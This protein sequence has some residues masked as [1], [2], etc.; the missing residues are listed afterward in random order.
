[1]LSM[2]SSCCSSISSRIS[3]TYVPDTEGSS[4]PVDPLA[5]LEKST[6]AKEHLEKVQIPRLEGL[7]DVSEHYNSD[8]YS[9]STKVRK[10]FRE[11]KKV[12]KQKAKADDQLRG[13]YGLPESLKL[14]EDDEKAR[15]EAKAEW[16]RGQRE[17]HLRESSKRRKL[18][19]E[20]VSVPSG[21]SSQRPTHITS[22]SRS[23]P[24]TSSNS[25]NELRARI[26][27]TTAR[28]S[29]VFSQPRS[30]RP[31]KAPTIAF[32]K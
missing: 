22:R 9:L 7:M 12:E 14:I 21:S 23:K 25:L 31:G 29:D 26:L 17:L 5:A 2:V 27:A 4:A 10:R 11:E 1:M 28:Q 8:P 19:V 18:A 30:A 15:A 13:R 6:D 24:S 20:V 16:E 32:N 3:L